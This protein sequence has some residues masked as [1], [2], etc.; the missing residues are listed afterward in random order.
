MSGP[1]YALVRPPLRRLRPLRAQEPVQPFRAVVALGDDDLAGESLARAEQLAGTSRLDKID[2][3]VRGHHPQLDDLRAL[4]EASKGKI[5]VATEQAEVTNRLSRCHFAVTSGDSWSLELA[6]V[7]IPQLMLVQAD[8]DMANAQMIEDH[9]V[10]TLLGRADKVN[11]V[12]M[13]NAVNGVLTDQLDR[14]TMAR[15]GRKLIDGRG[16]TGW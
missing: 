4:A 15:A 1:R 11:A 10:G 13:R 5:G 8:H 2:V 7:G 14:V 9:G 16:P 6:C 12:A 3:I